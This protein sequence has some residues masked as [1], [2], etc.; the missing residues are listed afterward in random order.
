MHAWR[1]VILVVS[2]WPLPRVA[3]DRRTPGDVRPAQM[4]LRST[5]GRLSS[6]RCGRQ[7]VERGRVAVAAGDHRGERAAD[8]R[9]LL[10][11]V[12]RE[13]AGGVDV[14]PARQRAGQ[15]VVVEARSSRSSRPRPSARAAPRR[16]ARARRAPARSARR[17][18]RGRSRRAALRRA[19]SS[20]GGAPAMKPRPSGRNQTPLG[21]MTSGQPGSG[22]RANR[23]R[24]RRAS[25]RP[26]AT[27]TP[28]RAASGAVHAPAASTTASASKRR[29]S[30]AQHGARRGR[31][32]SRSRRASA[33]TKRAPQ[34]TALRRNACISA[35]PSNQPSP[36]QP[37]RAERQVVDR[38]PRKAR[39][40]AASGDSSATS[41]PAARCTA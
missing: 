17:T 8:R 20:R 33:A 26:P 23:A 3:G 30:A 19:S 31:R 16:P 40:A 35:G 36:R 9:R 32:R 13:A 12:A 15:A 34:A 10:H 24:T 21:S 25:S 4:T 1:S 6:S 14:A 28:S 5:S 37:E 41:A 11:A 22:A 39:V 29:P 2:P 18:A 27:S 38:E 7:R